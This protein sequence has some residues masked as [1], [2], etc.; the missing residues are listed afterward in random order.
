MCLPAILE[1]LVGDHIAFS[2]NIIAVQ[3]QIRL[4][5]HFFRLHNQY[6]SKKS[7]NDARLGEITM[8]NTWYYDVLK[9]NTAS[10]CIKLCFL[11]YSVVEP[12]LLHACPLV[13]VTMMF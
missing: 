4:H 5:S 7:I 1:F 12:V 13:P 11:N 2:L 3:T 9:A 6:F 8:A 10:H